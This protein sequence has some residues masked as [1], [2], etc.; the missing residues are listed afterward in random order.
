VTVIQAE[1]VLEDRVVPPSHGEKHEFEIPGH[2]KDGEALQYHDSVYDYV[3]G[4]RDRSSA[5]IN[6][7]VIAHSKSQ[8]IDL[9]GKVSQTIMWY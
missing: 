8:D 7:D 3:G 2:G 1:G 4:R 5:T 6:Q 9:R